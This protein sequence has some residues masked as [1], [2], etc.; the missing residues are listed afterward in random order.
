M[1]V[2]S[3]KGVLNMVDG[4]D[5]TY[6]LTVWYFSSLKRPWV[7]DIELGPIRGF[8]TDQSTELRQVA[9]SATKRVGTDHGGHT[10]SFPQ[11]ETVRYQ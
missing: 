4:V 3:D 8:R 10:A 11:G 7:E 5:G 2:E 6:S 9:T 1:V